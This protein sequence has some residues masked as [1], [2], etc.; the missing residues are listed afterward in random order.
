[1]MTPQDKSI[2]MD[3]VIAVAKTCFDPEIPVDIW[4]LGL[5]YR[6]T[7]NDMGEVEII[8]TLTSPNCPV[9]ESLPNDFKNKVINNTMATKVDLKLTFEPPFSEEMMSEEA[10]L[11]LGLL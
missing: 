6:I 7:V 10:K 11:I 8:M 3:Q 1:M 5:I 9:I 4:E 2:L